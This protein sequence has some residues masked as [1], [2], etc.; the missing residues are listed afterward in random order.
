MFLAAQLLSFVTQPLAWCM[1]LLAGGLVLMP[2]RRK[3][4]TRLCHAALLVLVLS[5]WQVPAEGL[6]RYL[7]SRF[8]A[9]AV[10][11]QLG[12]YTGVVVLGG[13]LERAELWQVPGRI[14]LKGEA[15]RMIVPVGLMKRNP[16]LKMLFTG[17]EEGNAA[18]NLS[19]AARAKIVFD[20][21][22]VD[23]T[24]VM[25]ESKSRSTYEN[26]MFSAKAPGVDIN[27]RWLLLTTAAH[28]PRAMAVFQKAGWNVT[29]YS[30]DY[31]T[32][33]NTNWTDYSLRG[34]AEK[35]HYA[36]HEIMGYWMYRA[37]GRL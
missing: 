30:V 22:D 24:R 25:Y 10:D 18:S 28:M 5:G 2:Y 29:P 3:L 35:W 15:E 11:M 37:T 8:P 26:A 34:G 31:R 16:H 32:A 27:Q 20:L 19:E 14:A 6:M 9:P 17:G 4:A 1:L 21:L 13:A 23:P 7:E 12:T 33:A 36:L